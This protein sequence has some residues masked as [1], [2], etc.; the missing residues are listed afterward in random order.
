MIHAISFS[1]V[2]NEYRNCQLFL[3]YHIKCNVIKIQIA[4]LQRG[5]LGSIFYSEVESSSSE[6]T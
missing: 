3:R 2:Y 1:I 4:K 5:L 6:Y